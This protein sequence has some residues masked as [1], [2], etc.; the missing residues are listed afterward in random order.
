VTI[1]TTLLLW[2][3][4]LGALSSVS[5]PI[6]SALGLMLR[7][8]AAVTGTLAAFGAGALVAALSVELVAPTV[9][10]LKHPTGTRG[11]AVSHFLGLIIGSISGGLLFFSLDQ[12][13]NERGGFLR[14]T[15]T[16]ISYSRRRRRERLDAMLRELCGVDLLRKL[17]PDQVGLLVQDVRPVEYPDGTV[18]FEE[19]HP[20]DELYFVRQGELELQEG[21]R[22][23]LTLGPGDVVGELALVTGAPRT[24]SGRA[25]GPL[26]AFVLSHEAFERWRR[27][28]PEFDS[29]V[30]E[31]ASQR[32]GELTARREQHTGEARLWAQQAIAGLREGTQIPTPAELRRLREEHRGAPL[33]VW[34]GILLDG[35]PESLVIGGVLIGLGGAGQPELSFGDVIPYTL[36][37]GLF[38]SNLPEALSSSAQMYSQGWAPGRI[39]WM[40]TVLMIVTAAGAGVGY[41]AGGVLSEGALIGAEGVAAGA[42]LT[43]LASTMIPEAVHLGGRHVVGLSTLAGFLSAIS[44]KLFE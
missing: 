24:A 10:A 34:L 11:E 22:H 40:W 2:A 12:I 14:K 16:M 38:L 1:D 8:G 9:E 32:L 23:F 27:E 15:S 18:L 17:P 31:L 41:A 39:L 19:G 20:G 35:I 43:M 5:L 28:C 30:R 4:G 42:M 37:A 33:A 26:S 21:G 13:V 44:F 29:A 7:P 25:R 36:I 3:I 6:G